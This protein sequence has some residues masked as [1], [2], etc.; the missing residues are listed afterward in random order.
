[1][2]VPI[3]QFMTEEE[4]QDCSQLLLHSIILYQSAVNIT[5]LVSTSNLPD[6]AAMATPVVTAVLDTDIS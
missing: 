3:L 1:M 2:H 4:R 6:K 5:E